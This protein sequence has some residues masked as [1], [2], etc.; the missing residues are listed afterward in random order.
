MKFIASSSVLW[1]ALVPL[2]AAFPAAL[3]QEA[4][5][6]DPQL[7]ELLTRQQKTVDQATGIFEPSNTFNAEKQYI[8]VSEGSGHEYKPPGPNDL[9]GPCPGLN[10]FANHGFLPH[11]GYATIPQFV[12]ATTTV[13]GMGPLLATV[14]SL[15][16]G[17][18][19]GDGLSWSIG[20]QP[21][22]GVGGPLA[23][24]GT[25]LNGLHNRYEGDASPTRPDLYEEGNNFKTKANQ[26]QQLLDASPGDSITINSL[27]AFRSQ[28]FN[29]QIA[30]NPY[31]RLHHVPRGYK[32]I[33]R[34]D[35][36]FCNSFSMVSSRASSCSPLRT[37][38]FTDSWPTTPKLIPRVY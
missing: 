1:G 28:R 31:V 38:S 37:R 17:I 33:Y 27:T 12:E 30:N 3:I 4:F 6:K 24:A 23:R 15:L 21:P 20:G 19:G 2:I 29:T 32:D 18:Q 11:N 22:V 36:W 25:G 14:L 5:E 8:D 13:V 9:R 35:W 26:A 7:A 10:A 16:G 34:T